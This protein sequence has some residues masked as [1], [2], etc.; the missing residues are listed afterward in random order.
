MSCAAVES[1]NL[2]LTAIRS[3]FRYAVLEAPQH[4]ALIQR[5]LAIPNKRQLRPLVDLLTQPEFKALLAVPSATPG[6]DVATTLSC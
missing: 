1:R 4:A 6:W 5:V 2:C 3:F